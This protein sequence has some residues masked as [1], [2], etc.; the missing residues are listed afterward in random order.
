[1]TGNVGPLVTL[2][3]ADEHSYCLELE[4]THTFE[5]EGPG[6]TVVKA[7]APSV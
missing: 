1:M 7:S 5:L 6:A 3:R 2:V 4:R